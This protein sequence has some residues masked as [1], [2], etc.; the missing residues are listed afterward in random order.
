MIIKSQTIKI[1]SA[2][3]A[4]LHRLA[5]VQDETRKKEKLQAHMEAVKKLFAFAGGYRRSKAHMAE[6]IISEK[7]PANARPELVQKHWHKQRNILLSKIQEIEKTTG[8]KAQWH[9]FHHQKETIDGNQ[10]VH[11]HALI[12][13]Y[14]P[15]SMEIKNISKKEAFQ[16]AL[17]LMRTHAPELYQK[18]QK[19][20]SKKKQIGKKPIYDRSRAPLWFCQQVKARLLMEKKRTLEQAQT[21]PE[22]IKN[23]LQKL[24]DEA[25]A[26]AQ[27]RAP[28]LAPRAPARAPDRKKAPDFGL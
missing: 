5:H 22:R 19:A 12:I 8:L 4:F 16:W 28:T 9:L 26:K 25:Q 1:R 2:Y 3:D 18:T 7:L 13:L 6:L 20:L 14:K 27:A 15:L 11:T 23:K 10:N 24:L 21:R 17:D